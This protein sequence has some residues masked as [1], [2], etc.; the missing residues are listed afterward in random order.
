MKRI[1][2]AVCLVVL[3][4]AVV[5]KVQT[6]TVQ[7]GPEYKILDAWTGDWIIQEEAKDTPAEPA[8]RVDWT[9]KGQR[10]LGGFFL[11]V[12]HRLE[13]LGTVQNGLEVTGYDPIEKTCTTHVYYDNGS[14]IISKWTFISERTSV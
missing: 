1:A 7:S 2:I 3:A 4:S 6:S 11:E 14:L 10:I 5:S 13:F 9:L 8:Y 12:H